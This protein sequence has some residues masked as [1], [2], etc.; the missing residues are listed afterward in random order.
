[1]VW[2]AQVLGTYCLGGTLTSRLDRIHQ[3][4]G[5]VEKV[6]ATRD[7]QTAIPVRGRDEVARLAGAFNGML[8]ALTAIAVIGLAQI[9]SATGG[10][11]AI[12]NT[13]IYGMFLGM[14]ALVICLLWV[15]GLGAI[16]AAGS[17]SGY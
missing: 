2:P 14:I 15:I 16:M 6:A 4:T 11:S 17:A 9:Y 7:L 1:M 8:A 10:P 12:F 13:Q 5:A 3:L